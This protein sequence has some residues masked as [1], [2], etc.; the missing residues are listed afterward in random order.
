MSTIRQQRIQ[1]MLYQEISVMIENELE[2]P[3]LTLL[4]V[5]N[6][7]I[8]K[9]LRHAKIYV[10]HEDKSIGQRAILRGLEKATPFIRRQ[11]AARVNLRAVPDVLFFYDDTPERAARVDE[12][13]DRIR[14]ERGS[15]PPADEISAESATAES[16]TPG[17]PT[18]D[19]PLADSPTEVEGE[20]R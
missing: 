3:N 19:S 10:H 14:Q 8:S 12:L 20:G 7:V 15:A 18:T 16:A 2:D 5:T 6:V 4:K 9:D 1:E 17:S 13:L 11:L